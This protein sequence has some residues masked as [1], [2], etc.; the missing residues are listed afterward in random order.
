MILL[1]QTSNPDVLAISWETMAFT[2]IN[3][4]ILLVAFRFTLFKPVNNIIA[5]RQQEVEEDFN[6]AA[7]KQ[8]EAEKLKSEYEN[9]LSEI[10]Q[11]KKE[12]IQIAKKEADE[13]SNRIVGEAKTEAEEIKQKSVFEANAIKDQ[14]IKSTQKEIAEMVVDATKKVSGGVEVDASLY[15]EFLS[16][17]GEE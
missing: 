5:K 2:V 6:V 17:A 9:S 14:M 15:D 1:S 3:L 13:I 8:E 16:K 4:L 11:K 7:T 12:T 10:E